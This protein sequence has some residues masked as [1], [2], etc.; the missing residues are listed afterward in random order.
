MSAMRRAATSCASRLH[1]GAPGPDT[2]G[3]STK[4]PTMP[5]T[6]MPAWAREA[7]RRL[8]S[9]S[10]RSASSRALMLG[11]GEIDGLLTAAVAPDDDRLPAPRLSEPHDVVAGG[12]GRG[13]RAAHLVEARVAPLIVDPRSCDEPHEV[14]PLLLRP[15]PR[16]DGDPDRSESF[17]RESDAGLDVAPLDREVR[18]GLDD[19]GA[20]ALAVTRAQHG[21]GAIQQRSIGEQTLAILHADPAP[22]GGE[23]GSLQYAQMLLDAGDDGGIAERAQRLG[24]GAQPAQQDLA[25][26]RLARGPAREGHDDGPGHHRDPTPADRLHRRRMQ[27]RIDGAP[28][29]RGPR[30]RGLALLADCA[31]HC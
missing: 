31:T 13:G 1:T 23:T 18:L 21:E 2:G 22:E 10:Q 16:P 17:A 25:V 27:S 26:G 14:A 7:Q 12:E 20:G 29:G 15:P 28:R 4:L 8:S 6:A 9:P 24:L 19:R 11:Q 5:S 3:G 30:T